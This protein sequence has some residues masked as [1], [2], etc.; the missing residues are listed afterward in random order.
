MLKPTGMFI[1]TSNPDIDSMYRDLD[2]AFSQLTEQGGPLT[3]ALDTFIT[4]T[5]GSRY[6]SSTAHGLVATLIVA[7]A[8]TQQDSFGVTESFPGLTIDSN[9]LRHIEAL[10]AWEL[11]RN[12]TVETVRAV[13]ELDVYLSRA[14][15]CAEIPE[16]LSKALTRISHRSETRVIDLR[17]LTVIMEANQPMLLEAADAFHTAVGRLRDIASE[18][19]AVM[20]GLKT[21]GKRAELVQISK[22]AAAEEVYDPIT[23]MTR[24]QPSFEALVSSLLSNLVSS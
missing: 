7:L 3:V 6:P 21:D 1:R 8:D 24:F 20:E 22:L 9:E 15:R 16:N 10:R 23:L 4:V 17:K 11:W 19:A 18:A 5:G 13:R 2:E 14:L 12:L